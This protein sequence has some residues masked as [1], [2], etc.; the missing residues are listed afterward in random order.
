MRFV[1][2]RRWLGLRARGQTL[3]PFDAV[4]ITVH[5]R[6]PVRFLCPADVGVACVSGTAWITTTANT[7]DVVLEAGDCQRAS[8]G[9]VLVICGLHVCELRIEAY[10]PVCLRTIEA[11][12][13][14]RPD[15]ADSRCV[16]PEAGHLAKA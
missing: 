16:L 5:W 10:T 7:R 11:Q 6:K 1:K 9:D 2:L 8:S 4:R 3:A 14:D 12:P 13:R 15:Q